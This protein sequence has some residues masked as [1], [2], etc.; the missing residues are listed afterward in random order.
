MSSNMERENTAR[1]SPMV[2]VL[3]ATGSM[4]FRYNDKGK[5]RVDLMNQVLRHFIEN[6]IVETK[7]RAALEVAFV[8][9]TD[10]IVLTT[11]FMSLDEIESK[12]FHTNNKHYQGCVTVVDKVV[13]DS[14]T[15][16]KYNAH[17][18]VF[19]V[20]K[21]DNGTKIGAAVLTGLSL[22]EDRV[23][24]RR[25]SNSGCY[26]PFLILIT[27]GHPQ[28]KNGEWYK[29]EQEDRAVAA[30]TSHCQTNG[31]PDNLIVPFVIGVGGDDIATDTLARYSGGFIKGFFHVDDAVGEA[32]MEVVSEL[33]C[34]SIKKSVTL[35]ALYMQE[36]IEEAYTSYEKKRRKIR[37]PV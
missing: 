5:S 26:P 18:P 23:R 30:V 33:I 2:F 6:L 13:V 12:R 17:I 37:F 16:K 8:V 9:F 3:D 14:K 31:N 10:E 29:D 21:K 4:L 20:S 19:T 11:D 36:K 15:N 35:N 22:L 28:S 7:V 27:D 25:N 1:R 32:L 34:K 24:M